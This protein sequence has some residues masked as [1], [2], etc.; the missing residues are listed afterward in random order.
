[1]DGGA[2]AP[3][4]KALAKAPRGETRAEQPVNPLKTVF[5]NLI[6]R[7]PPEFSIALDY[8]VHPRPRFGHGHPTHPQLYKI[9]AARR[10]DY[11]ALLEKFLAYQSDIW[12]ISNRDPADARAPVWV[13]GFIPAL[14]SISLYSLVRLNSPRLYIEIGSGHSTRFARKAADDGHL[15]TKI[16]SIDPHPRVEVRSIADRIVEQPLEDTSLDLFDSLDRGDILF[17]DNSHRVF[18]NSDVAIVFLEILPK[19]KPGVLVH[20][21]DI[22]LPDDYPA[23]WN[24]RYYSEQY[25]LACHLLAQTKCFEIVLPN[26]F[27][28]GDQE[29]RSGI[30]PMFNHPSMQG[31]EWHGCSFWVRIQETVIE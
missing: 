3:V 26:M 19:L 27:I 4:P 14:D 18:T 31:V 22:F 7:K 20:F 11:K 1:M 28:C 24:N 29:I 16:V 5:A 6:R 15:N 17:V 21:H 9:I 8:P 30:S 12:R 13:N 25:L 10:N 23:D 2:S